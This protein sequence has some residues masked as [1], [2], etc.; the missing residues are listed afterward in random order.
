MKL[1]IVSDQHLEFRL[2]GGSHLKY[3]NPVHPKDGETADICV[4][5]GDF[6]TIRPRSRNFFRLLC[7]RER[8][9]LFVPGN[10]EYYGCKSMRMVDDTLAEFEHEISNLKVLRTG[11]V[12]LQAGT[13]FLGDTMWVPITDTLL[14][15]ADE[16]NDPRQIPRLLNEIGERHYRFVTWLEQELRERDVVVTHHL[17]TI[18]SVQPRHRESRTTPWY[19]APNMERF[20]ERKPRAWIHG[21][22]HVRCDY[23][24]GQTRLVC[25]PVGY[26]E[27]AG[28]L[29]GKLAPTVFNFEKGT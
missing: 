25:N 12:F 19:V 9:V 27:D 13:R 3:F 17:P 11:E 15:S 21:H 29:P 6:D 18:R 8:Q 26:P 16:M 24:Y 22:V 23:W 20:F 28:R 4:I 14:A 7:E 2:S 1:K 10:H 5:A